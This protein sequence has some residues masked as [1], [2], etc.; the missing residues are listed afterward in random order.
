MLRS[1]EFQVLAAPIIASILVLGALTARDSLERDQRASIQTAE[2]LARELDQAVDRIAD[3]HQRTVRRAREA[4]LDPRVEN[5]IAILNWTA[6]H[7]LRA[8][9][10]HTSAARALLSEVDS[11]D[12]ERLKLLATRTGERLDDIDTEAALVAASLQSIL[13]G[14]D[15]EGDLFEQA[16]LEFERTDRQVT[17]TLRRLRAV[18]R[19]T[20]RWLVE[21]RLDSEPRPF[22]SLPI[23]G[24]ICAISFLLAALPLWRLRRNALG[25]LA[26]SYEQARHEQDIRSQ[27]ELADLDSQLAEAA[28]LA[29][30]AAQ[31]ERRLEQELALIRIYNDNLVNSLRSAVLVTDLD[32]K[33]TGFN[34]AARELFELSSEHRGTSIDALSLGPALRAGGFVADASPESKRQRF[35][36]LALPSNRVVDLTVVPY[37]DESGA[38]RGYLWLID[39]VT[40][41]METKHQLLAAER[42]ATVGRLA[43]QVA[44]EIRNPLSAI[45]LNAELLEDE[46]GEGLD[47]AAR[48]ESR[49]LLRAIGTEVERLNEV[50]EGYLKLAR[51]PTPTPETVDLNEAIRDLATMLDADLQSH[52]VDVQLRLAHPSPEGWVDANQLRQALLNVVR[53]AREALGG[54]PGRIVFHT[55]ATAQESWVGVEDNGPGI[56]SELKSR[57]LE[58]FFTTKPQGTG[59]G[60]SLTAQIVGDHGGRI[61]IDGSPGQGTR[62]RMFFPRPAASS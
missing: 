40:E 4:V 30:R 35:P 8:M 10:S 32:S 56:P 43:A 57:V 20:T 48:E 22:L 47:A 19:R 18:A 2:L 17:S 34:R 55:G 24:G 7:Y 1:L 21:R 62:I 6:E 58:P 46:L 42:L 12:D 51:M 31:S 13:D 11:R 28:R 16:L 61:E 39:D 38:A 45:G 26:S 15:G 9:R 29:D 27:A 36:N 3:R 59:L 54:A 60:L 50:T 44:H 23:L 33:L 25:P 37:L 53:N 49:N 14:L 52:G 5:R 41:A